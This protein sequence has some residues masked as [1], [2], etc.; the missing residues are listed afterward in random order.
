MRKEGSSAAIARTCGTPGVASRM[1]RTA[2]DCM[3]LIALVLQFSCSA[4]YDAIDKSVVAVK[5]SCGGN[6]VS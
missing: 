6:C 5:A 2:W 1:A 4:A 3:F